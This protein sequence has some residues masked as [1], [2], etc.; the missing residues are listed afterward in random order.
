[1]NNKITLYELLGLIKDGQAPKRIKVAGDVYEYDDEF[2]I[3]MCD[4]KTYRVALGGMENKINLICNAFNEIVEILD[5]E[6][7]D[8]EEIS[9]DEKSVLIKGTRFYREKDIEIFQKLSMT[10]NELV[11]EVNKLKKGNHE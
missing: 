8:I 5:S 7:E 10:I 3:Y 4:K 1:M 11:R 9:I 6:D 2:D